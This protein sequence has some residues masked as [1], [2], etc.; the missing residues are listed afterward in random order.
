[1][2]TTSVRCLGIVGFLFGH[3]YLK[4]FAAHCLSDYCWR[5]GKP[6]GAGWVHT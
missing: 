1:M 6:V 4:G 5:C 3:K 2:T